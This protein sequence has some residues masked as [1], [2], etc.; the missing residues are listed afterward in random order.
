MVL[1]PLCVAGD[2]AEPES[3]VPSR[4][5][6]IGHPAP[7]EFGWTTPGETY[8]CLGQTAAG[9]HVLVRR[10]DKVG[11][12]YLPFRDEWGHSTAD[13]STYNLQLPE[14]TLVTKAPAR[15]SPG[16]VILT[17][18]TPYPATATGEDRYSVSFVFKDLATTVTV[19][20][21]QLQLPVPKDVEAAL[22]PANTESKAVETAGPAAETPAV[23]E[24]ITMEPAPAVEAAPLPAKAPEAE[25]AAP[26]QPE[27]KP[28][29]TVEVTP[30]LKHVAVGANVEASSTHAG[31]KGE[32]KPATLVD[33]DLTTRWSSEYAEPQYV[34][35]DLGKPRALATVRLHWETASAAAYRVSASVDGKEWVL[36]CERDLK[37]PDRP[38]PR[39]DD[40]DMQNVAVGQ[41]RLD[42]LRRVNPGWGFSLYEIELIAAE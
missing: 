20:R 2:P 24:V 27:T 7:F 18:G 28:M 4:D 1:V 10:D 32:G 5:I 29:P 34:I 16:C 22:E 26:P 41:I 25:K 36:V 33:G 23:D 21:A 40:I 37:M 14:N 8:D 11:I 39:V 6:V 31:L 3:V 12:G 9:Y 13:S 38:Q 42:L 15:L 17:K 35:V 19:D 30:L